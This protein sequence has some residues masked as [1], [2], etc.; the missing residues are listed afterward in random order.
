MPKVA[1]IIFPSALAMRRKSNSTKQYP[2]LKR[3]LVVVVAGLRTSVLPVDMLGAATVVED[4]DLRSNVSDATIG[5][6]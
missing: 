3:H 5:S 1:T 4:G 6:E 2:Y